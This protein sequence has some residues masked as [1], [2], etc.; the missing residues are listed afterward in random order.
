MH[1]LSSFSWRA[2]S[3]NNMVVPNGQYAQN[4]IA[5]VLLMAIQNVLKLL[6]ELIYATV[7]HLEH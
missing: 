1:I 6:I 3:D 4:T 7:C 2:A 5:L